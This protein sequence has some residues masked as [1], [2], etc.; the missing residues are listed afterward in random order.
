MVYAPADPMLESIGALEA[1]RAAI[2]ET[3]TEAYTLT[4]S[5]EEVPGADGYEIEFDGMRYT[6]IR[7]TRL[8]FE[9]LRPESDYTFRIR[10]VNASG[11]SPWSTLAARTK[12]DPL[13]F[14]I[15]GLSGETSCPNRADRASPGSSTST[16][17]IHGTRAGASGPCPFDLVIDLHSINTL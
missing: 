2:A 14:A 15:R 16:S 8:R 12:S 3:D 17:R 10:A 1:P 5:W 6:M 13:E 9:D 11:A 7:D 4:P